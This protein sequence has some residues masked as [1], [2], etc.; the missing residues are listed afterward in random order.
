MKLLWLWSTPGTA[1]MT[2]RKSGFSVNL[3]SWS[4]VVVM[5]TLAD[6]MIGE[7]PG[8]GSDTLISSSSDSRS[9]TLS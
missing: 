5:D 3:A 4:M 8:E 6:L 1:W 2:D 9:G 7:G